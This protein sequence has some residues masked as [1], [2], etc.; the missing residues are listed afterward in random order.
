MNT[1]CNKFRLAAKPPT[2]CCLRM[3]NSTCRG[4]SCTGI[5]WL[6]VISF[7]LH[8]ISQA[9]RP[10]RHKPANPSQ[11]LLPSWMFTCLLLKQ[12]GSTRK[13]Q[14]GSYMTLCQK[15]TH[16]GLQSFPIVLS[17]TLIFNAN[18][19][20]GCSSWGFFVFSSTWL[21]LALFIPGPV[22]AVRVCLGFCISE[23]HTTT[24]SALTYSCKAPKTQID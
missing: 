3:R 18:S 14:R 4:K 9:G 6:S 16:S 11:H 7:S 23:K 10:L 13:D 22:E 21:L 1:W 5:M 20:L 17:W 24:Y 15:S 2:S 12:T 19:G 8:V